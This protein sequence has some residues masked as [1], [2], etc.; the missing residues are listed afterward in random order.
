MTRTKPTTQVELIHVA[1]TKF[2]KF[3][4]SLKPVDEKNGWFFHIVFELMHATLT[5]YNQLRVG[6]NGNN[7][8]LLAW[9]CRNLLELAILTKYVL[10]SEASARRFTH[11]RLIDGCD[12]LTS[13]TALQLYLAPQSDTSLADESL[14]MMQAQMAV[15][16]VT[17]TKHLSTSELANIVGMTEDY[18]CMNR[19]CSKL[20]HATAWSVL[21]M[22]KEDNSFSQARQIFFDAGA[23]YGLD[24]YAA[25]REHNA[26]YGMKPK[27]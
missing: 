5:N 4:E 22:N 15:E 3:G 8:P 24:V 2:T 26:T 10:M 19:I 11:D 13:M 1:F 6:Y 20:V 18:K 23:Q 14:V 25:V 21:A 9:E 12:I 27:P 16:G 17:A 7:N